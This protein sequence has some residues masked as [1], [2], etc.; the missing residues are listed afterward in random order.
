MG[1]RSDVKYVM[2]F[3]SDDHCAEFIAIQKMKGSVYVEVANDWEIKGDRI[4]FHADAWKWYDGY[5]VV[6]AHNTSLE[7][8]T[9]FGGSYIFY[10]LGENDDDTE[11]RYGESADDTLDV[12]WDAIN[13]HRYT[14]FEY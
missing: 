10:R 9:E 13:F 6:E 8:C 1:Y 7:D 12:P 3:K 14:E 5:P 4:Y 11:E 2:Q